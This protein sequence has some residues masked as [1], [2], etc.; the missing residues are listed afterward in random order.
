MLACGQPRLGASRTDAVSCTARGAPAR[1]RLCGRRC[2]LT[3]RGCEPCPLPIEKINAQ[4]WMIAPWHRKSLSEFFA[5]QRCRGLSPRVQG[6][7][8]PASLSPL[9]AS[10]CFRGPCRPQAF[11]VRDGWVEN[12]P[13]SAQHS[14]AVFFA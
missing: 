7:C 4:L 11:R 6:L 14:L 1:R 3:L 5:H 13:E 12:T 9:L 2:F 10:A 8:L